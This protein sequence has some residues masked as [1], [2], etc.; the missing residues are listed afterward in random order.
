MNSKSAHEL[1][2]KIFMSSKNINKFNTFCELEIQYQ[3]KHKLIFMRTRTEEISYQYVE[4]Q[5]R[6]EDYDLN[7]ID[8]S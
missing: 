3:N 2:L 8:L 4:L 6:N 7:T 1:N 5:S